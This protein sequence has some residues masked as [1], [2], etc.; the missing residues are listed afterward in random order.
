MP[1]NPEQRP[2]QRVGDVGRDVHKTGF[3][4]AR[5]ERRLGNIELMVAEGCQVEARGV[6]HGD[7]LAAGKPL[8]AQPRSAER[9]G[10]DEVAAQQHAGGGILPLELLEQRR[11]PRQAARFAPFDRR[12]LV[13]VIDVEQGDAHGAV[14]LGRRG[15]PRRAR[16]AR[17]ERNE[18]QQQPSQR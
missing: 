6:E 8:A 17:A 16:R 9:G 3:A 4:D 13:D 1:G 7:H 11:H 14:V 2:A 12:D 15:S 10:R 18:R 5:R